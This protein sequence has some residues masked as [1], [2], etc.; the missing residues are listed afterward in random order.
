MRI[1]LL[2]PVDV[3]A[4]GAVREVSGLRRKATLAVLALNRGTVVSADQLIDVVWDGSAPAT[5]L[6]TLQRNI[7]Y[8]RQVLG[9]RHSIVARSPGYLLEV[10]AEPTDA[11]LAE[12]VLRVASG[13]AASRVRELNTV[14]DLW[15]GPSLADV[16]ALPW[17]DRHAQRLDRMRLQAGQ[18]LVDARLALGEHLPLLPELEQRAGEHPFDERTQRQLILALYRAGRQVEALAAFR[19]LRADL[20]EE[21][22]IDPGPE[23]RELESAMLRQDAALTAV[24][25]P[26]VRVPAQLPLAVRGFV[27]RMTELAVLDDFAGVAVVSGGAGFGKTSLAVHW[28]HRAAKRFPDG[29]LYV[30]LRGFGP[31]GNVMDPAAAVR[32]FLGAFEVPVAR[33]P[34]GYDE[35]VALYRSLLAGKRVLILLDNARD[36]E[37]VRPLLPGAPGCVVVV[38]S[39]DRLAP[40][41][42]VEGALAVGVGLFSEADAGEMLGRRLGEGRLAAEPRAVLE[43]MARCAGLPLALSIV[44]ARAATRPGQPL[45]ALAAQLA[46]GAEVL[47]SLSAGDPGSDLRAVFSWS[48]RALRPDAARLFRLL[49][50]H[51][52]PDL[53]VGAAA[54]LAGL[55]VRV[56]EA[57]LDDLL[58]ASLLTEHAPG[59][60]VLHDLLRVYALEQGADHEARERL[61][62]HYLHTAQT[63]SRTL[64]GPWSD[65]PLAAPGPGVTPEQ[66]V[67]PEAAN[68]WFDVEHHVLL[69][70][71]QLAESAGLAAYAWRLAWSLSLVLDSRGFWREY[72]ETQRS[73]LEAARRSGDAVGLAHAEH[74]LGRAYSCLCRDS[75]ALPLLHSALARYA[76]VGDIAG[77]ANVHLGIGFVADRAGDS[78][79]AMHCSQ[80]ALELFRA[81]GHRSGQAM[82]LSNIGWSLAELGEFDAAR[83]LCEQGLALHRELGDPRGLAG[84]WDSLGYAHQLAGRHEDAIACYTTGLALA[85]QVGD[86]FVQADLLSRLGD[87]HGAVGAL[88]QARVAWRE[89]LVIFDELCHASA[90]GLRQKL[91]RL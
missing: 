52:G 80:Q 63:A 11:E 58:G 79:L 61:F 2:G 43:I 49:G 6:N 91:G 19:R 3:D 71:V 38:T 34:A 54:S 7:S 30:N 65:L 10:G 33:I 88:S 29:Q 51:P 56:V 21:L 45:A 68:A 83:T 70:L 47:D 35:Q 82:A 89:A 27:G 50:M 75:E 90:E 42:A 74:G 59:R 39:R 16:C 62:E 73:A 41:V 48:F 53:G 37:Q 8:L 69:G 36:A 1:R 32:G 12:R 64:H 9:G 23:L 84:S 87:T 20:R 26:V 22:G 86:R 85:R 77:Q 24:S 81:A 67:R 66:P 57:L 31:A 15:R 78:A 60:F 55:S 13:S 44:A 14:L 17:L 76:A 28:A 72:R 25:T 18:D 46:E 5:G 40:M 4:D